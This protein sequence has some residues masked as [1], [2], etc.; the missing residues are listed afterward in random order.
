MLLQQHWN[1]CL[2]NVLSGIAYILCRKKCIQYRIFFPSVYDASNAISQDIRHV[3][4]LLARKFG[5]KAH[6]LSVQSVHRYLQIHT[7]R[8]NY[9]VVLKTINQEKN[10]VN[11]WIHKAL[12]IFKCKKVKTFFFNFKCYFF[13]LLKISS[14]L[15]FRI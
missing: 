6:K 15:D 8:S 5:L 4:I 3:N 11:L 7:H 2:V 9:N 14:T 12:F 10:K 1:K 13:V